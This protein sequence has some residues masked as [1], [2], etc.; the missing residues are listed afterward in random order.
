MLLL[1]LLRRQLRNYHSILPMIWE[2]WLRLCALALPSSL[3]VSNERPIGRGPLTR[4]RSTRHKHTHRAG[5]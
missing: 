2:E 4:A 1:M 3:I 5:S